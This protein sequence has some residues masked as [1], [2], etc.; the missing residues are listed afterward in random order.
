MNYLTDIVLDGCKMNRCTNFFLNKGYSLETI[1]KY[2]LGYYPKGV[3][4]YAHI[5]DEDKKVLKCYKYIIPEIN[6][7]NEIQY[8]ILR[9]D[10]E[11]VLK[12]LN[13]NIDKHFY[14]GA[15]DRNLWNKK[16]LFK[17]NPVFICE[18]W[19]DALSVIDCGFEAVSLNRIIN[20]VELW[21]IVRNFKKQR[22]FLLFGDNDY[23]GKQ[24]ND[25][26]IRMLS[27]EKRLWTV[28]DNFPSNIKDANEWFLF[29]KNDFKNTLRRKYN[30]LL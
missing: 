25:N 19:T 2:K 12:Q 22:K 8:L 13:F 28:V 9:S 24:A 17:D 20:I 21:K 27:A 11:E 23:Y 30:E 15:S 4:A 7:E 26:L 10:R 14:V 5:I 1:E 29:D 18:T 3:S 6:Q 16:A